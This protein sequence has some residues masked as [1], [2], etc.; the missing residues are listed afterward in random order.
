MLL[1]FQ[2]VVDSVKIQDLLF[3]NILRTNRQ[4]FKNKESCLKDLVIFLFLNDKNST[5]YG[6]LLLRKKK[7]TKTTINGVKISDNNIIFENLKEK[8]KK[9]RKVEILFDSFNN[10]EFLFGF[11]YVY[12]D[13]HKFDLPPIDILE[14]PD[15]FETNTSDGTPVFIV[16]NQQLLDNFFIIFYTMK[17]RNRND[18]YPRDLISSSYIEEI[19]SVFPIYKEVFERNHIELENLFNIV[20]SVYNKHYEQK[21]INIEHSQVNSQ[22]TQQ[23][24]DEEI[25]NTEEFRNLMRIFHD[26][27]LVKKMIRGKNK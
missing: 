24:T 5:N 17:N 13:L 3:Q 2:E 15:F 21:K 27:E 6:V 7:F 11:E 12:H 19:L 14:I 16:K 9:D 25:K 4:F 8:Y 23:N 22:E 18:F 26:E 20:L 1:D 10:R